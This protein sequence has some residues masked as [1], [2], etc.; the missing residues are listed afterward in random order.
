MTGTCR[1]GPVSRNQGGA[2]RP[3]PCNGGRTTR[4]RVFWTLAVVPSLRRGR[5]DSSGSGP[6][7]RGTRD[8]R[9]P[10]GAAVGD[11]SMLSRVL[12]LVLL[13]SLPAARRA[14][15]VTP[16]EALRIEA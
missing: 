8:R 2:V 16:I 1:T 14:V 13:A 12:L 9:V 15:R 4:Q 10:R 3:V 7:R 6:V 11:L 5:T